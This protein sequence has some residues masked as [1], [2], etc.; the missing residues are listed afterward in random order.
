MAVD[1][2]PVTPRGLLARGEREARHGGASVKRVVSCLAVVVLGALLL[3]FASEEVAPVDVQRALTDGNR[4]FRNG[5]LEEAVEAY[6]AG[7]AAADPHPTLAYNLGTTYHQLNRLPEAIL[8]YRRAGE[9]DPWRQENLWLAR[10]TLGSQVMEPSGA[11]GRLFPLAEGLRF[12]AI[13]LSWL[14]LIALIASSKMPRWLI[15]AVGVLAFALFAIALVA[16]RWSPRPAVLLED[17][18]SED[19]ELP[20][21]TE[22]WVR[23]RPDGDWTVSGTDGVVCSA[24]SA[25]LIFP[26]S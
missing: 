7:Y 17:C 4:L 6:R 8:W 16:E 20:A 11:L 14:I 19:G 10:R 9:G 25:E 5:Q 12:V 24:G 15:V 23:P 22:V 1:R 21:G 18:F 2:D 3:A 13:A 26:P